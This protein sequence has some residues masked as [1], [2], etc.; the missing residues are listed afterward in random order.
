MGKSSEYL[1]EKE[2]RSIGNGLLASQ[3]PSTLSVDP[4]L[5]QLRVRDQA[6]VLPE[7][8]QRLV[9]PA[10]LNSE[11][12]RAQRIMNV[13]GD[14]ICFYCDG[15]GMIE[16]DL[17]KISGSV[18]TVEN[19]IEQ[20]KEFAAASLPYGGDMSKAM[21]ARDRDAIRA[22]MTFNRERREQAAENAGSCE[23]DM[24]AMPATK[25]RLLRSISSDE[26]KEEKDEDDFRQRQGV[27]AS[28]KDADDAKNRVTYGGILWFYCTIAEPIVDVEE[29]PLPYNG[30]IQAAMRNQDRAAIKQIMIAKQAKKKR[31]HLKR[32]ES[33]ES[34]DSEEEWKQFS[35]LATLSLEEAFQDG[36]GAQV[37][38]FEPEMGQL[39]CDL[40][41]MNLTRVDDERSQNNVFYKLKRAIQSYEEDGES[42]TGEDNEN[43]AEGLHETME[44]MKAC[45]VCQ[46]TGRTSKWMQSLTAKETMTEETEILCEVCGVDTASYGISVECEH[47]FCSDCISNTLKAI[48]DL[49]QFPACCPV[50]RVQNDGQA[51]DGFITRPVLTF[52]EQRSVIEKDFQFRFVAGM[53]RYAERNGDDHGLGLTDRNESMLGLAH[54]FACPAKCGQFLIKEKP[55]FD[56]VGAEVHVRLGECPCG[57]LVCPQ[58]EKLHLSLSERLEGKSR[59]VKPHKCKRGVSKEAKNAL[60]RT[61]NEEKATASAMA[62]LGKACPICG[63]FIQKVRNLLNATLYLST[64]NLVVC[65][66]GTL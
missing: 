23:S 40:G 66:F 1:A 51:V 17:N 28:S 35:S 42:N 15:S 46:G 26:G 36:K 8:V 44:K 22:I 12:Q 27:V 10:G 16:S 41:K 55:K 63:M 25:P 62:K 56:I 18:N 43:Q 19:Q 31:L 32:Q 60:Q 7:D 21:A 30:D 59:H 53:H 2:A 5:V 52:L 58:C 47:L 48:L 3:N 9:S 57:A 13:E 14:E 49:G 6:I 54:H 39:R 45:W 4:K 33:G 29:E 50:C 34:K 61:I 11:L 65:S 20:S 37:M 38:C 24:E 64:A